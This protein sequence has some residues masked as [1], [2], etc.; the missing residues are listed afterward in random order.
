M[1]IQANSS[2]FTSELGKD[3]KFSG[4]TLIAANAI[5]LINIFLKNINN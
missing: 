3:K 1:N 2:T 5:L 4:N